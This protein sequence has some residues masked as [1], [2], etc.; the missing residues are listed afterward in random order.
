[1]S[2]SYAVAGQPGLT[3]DAQGNGFDAKCPKCGTINHLRMSQPH[4]DDNYVDVDKVSMTC[5]GKFVEDGDVVPCDYR[6]VEG[7]LIGTY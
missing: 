6:V 3:L 5:A 1:M 7:Q 2:M 4:P